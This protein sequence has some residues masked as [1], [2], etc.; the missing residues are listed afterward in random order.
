MNEEIKTKA[1]FYLKQYA[2][3][4]SDR[5]GNIK[6]CIREEE[7]CLA[8]VP[9]GNDEDSK[10]CR[11]FQQDYHGTKLQHWTDKLEKRIS[12]LNEIEQIITQF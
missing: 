11:E 7:K 2:E 10:T 8:S 6:E 9:K 3:N 1:K 4:L 5:I 12:A